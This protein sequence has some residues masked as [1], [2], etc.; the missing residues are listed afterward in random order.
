MTYSAPPTSILT[1]K[2]Y[3]FRR[4]TIRKAKKVSTTAPPNVS[5]WNRMYVTSELK[6]NFQNVFFV[7]RLFIIQL[8]DYLVLKK[9]KYICV[10]GKIM[11]TA[12]ELPLRHLAQ[13]LLYNIHTYIYIIFIQV[14][15]LHKGTDLERRSL[16]GILC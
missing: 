15:L 7:D 2:K 4:K 10:R 6:I 5:I 3:F 11:K 13:L 14:S 1:L 16:F 12:K 9:V 8:V